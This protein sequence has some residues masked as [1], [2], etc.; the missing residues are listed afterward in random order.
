MSTSSDSFS[1]IT[2]GDPS[3][4]R[5]SPD[6]FRDAIEHLPHG[7]VIYDAEGR[8]RYLNARGEALCGR[9]AAELIGKRD[10]ELWPPEVTGHYLP[11][12]ERAL[13]SGEPQSVEWSPQDAPHHTLLITYLPL[14]GAQGQVTQVTALTD[15]ITE[16]K[17]IAEEMHALLTNARCI[18]W[19]ADV[20]GEEGWE[21]DTEN[22]QSKLVWQVHVQDNH[23]AQQVLPL[24]ALEGQ[25]YAAAWLA[26]CYPADRPHMNETARQALSSGAPGYRQEFRCTDK[27]GQERWLQE[28]TVIQPIEPG[29][30]NLYGVVTDIT[31]RKQAEEQVR[32]SEERYRSLFEHNVDGIF[33]VDLSGRFTDAN[34]AALQISGYTLDELKELT[35]IDL[36]AP[37]MLP[38][39]AESFQTTLRGVIQP[40]ETVMIRKDGERIDLL[41]HGAP[42]V[43]DGQITGIFGVVVDV[44]EQKRAAEALKKSERSFRQLADAMPQLVWTADPDGNVDYYNRRVEEFSGFSQG[45]DGSWQWAPVLHPDDI[46]IT[47]KAWE[48]AIRTGVG[49]EIEH[50]VQRADGTYRWY[51]S[52]GVPARDETGA[53]IKWY[54]TATD[55]DDQK[56][57]A[58]QLRRHAER[59]TLLVEISHFILTSPEAGNGLTQAV[60]HKVREHLDADVCVNYRFDAESATLHL[61]A[62]AGIPEELSSAIQHLQLGESFCGVVAQTKAPLMADAVRIQNDPLGR[63][64]HH[65]ALRSFACQP[66][67]AGDGQLLGTLSF[68]S[69]R[70]DRFDPEEVNFLQTLCHFVAL[71]WERKQAEARLR[72]QARLLDEAHEAIFAWE[73]DGGI[74]YWNQGAERLYGYPA[75]EAIGKNPHELLLTQCEGGI[76]ALHEHLRKN[77]DWHGELSHIKRDGHRMTVAGRFSLVHQS[78]GKT[79]VIEA[80]RDITERKRAEQA[81]SFLAEAGKALNAS[82]DYSATLQNV[83]RLCVPRLGEGCT[84]YITNA[85]G[86]TVQTAVAH[87]DPAKEELMHE[88]QRRFPFD[89]HTRS[90]YALPLHEGNSHLETDITPESLAQAISN[91]E[92]LDLL[93]RLN[94]RSTLMVPLI[95]EGR[96][97]GALV[98]FAPESGWNYDEHDQWLTE[99]LARRASVAIERA[100]LFSEAQQARQAAED[101]NR[102]KDEFLS[103]VSHELRTPLTPILGWVDILRGSIDDSIKQHALDVLQRNVQAQSKLVNDILDVS[104]IT[105][106]KLRLEIQTTDLSK[107]VTEAIESL[108][109]AA[110]AKEIKLFVNVAHAPVILQCDAARIRQVVWN[111]LSNAIKFT[112]AGGRVEVEL[113]HTETF[114]EIEVRDS[115]IGIKS[116]FLPFVFER[117]Q[118]ADSSHTREHGGLGLGLNIVRHI[119]EMH[120]GQVSADSKGEGQGAIFTV[121]LPVHPSELTPVPDTVHPPVAEPR[122]NV[123]KGVQVLLVDDEPDVLE[124]VTLMLERQGARVRAVESANDA[125]EIVG[126]W[127]PDVMIFDITMPEI[128]GHDLLAKI[129]ALPDTA[130]SNVPALVLS[131]SATETDRRLSLEAGFLRHLDKPIHADA[132]VQAVV[133]ALRPRKPTAPPGK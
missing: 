54:G 22:R 102:A 79:L 75:A 26:S 96:F 116:D 33:S 78:D 9:K 2:A 120:T 35:F 115:G 46:E 72:Q 32:A 36:A 76:E 106:G 85:D 3:P 128:D 53:F 61:V 50:R 27:F 60:F 1:F 111:L 47:F 56:R 68:G 133:E 44:T 97:G 16:R 99:E 25:D 124:M 37:E 59:Q 80:N 95:T 34:P 67:L 69:K 19:S 17:R 114:A 98:V 64:V 38:K 127:H 10:D 40:L 6:F 88:I 13:A 117:F 110:T 11:Y 71:A 43:I 70:R 86:T 83:A 100:R 30:W 21:Q 107:A 104:R 105:T 4:L 5:E 14:R 125:L 132:L 66:L 74:I 48:T 73:M 103:V 7:V 18:L 131:A 101:A 89:L 121:R 113:R 42:M 63:L 130:L 123:L 41:I 51:L 90:R 12:L 15:D 31:E 91:P 109:P 20:H 112:P 45:E 108:F 55:I 119:V 8:F 65:L 58:E 94:L 28:E 52:R 82:L 77:N 29:Q 62:H 39:T 24:N 81:L 129:R 126:D 122:I 49:Y 92:Y 57:A 87:R 23:A 84:I 118:Q 93:H